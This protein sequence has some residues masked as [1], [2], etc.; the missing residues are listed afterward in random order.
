MIYEATI[1]IE[2]PINEVFEVATCRRRCAVWLHIPSSRLDGDGPARVGSTFTGGYH[3]LG[4]TYP[5]RAIITELDAPLSFAF[6]TIEGHEMSGGYT[7][8]P[9]ERGTRFRYINR[10]EELPVLLRLVLGNRLTKKMTESA[11][12]K[13]LEKLKMLME[14]DVD[15]WALTPA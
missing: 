12:R 4:I 7:F 15:L 11:M 5:F 13:E 14:N 8:T 1:E 3:F 6:K 2:R 10:V 9:T